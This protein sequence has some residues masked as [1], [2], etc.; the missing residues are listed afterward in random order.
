MSETFVR[1]NQYNIAWK[2]RQSFKDH[3]PL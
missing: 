3:L 2:E 1:N